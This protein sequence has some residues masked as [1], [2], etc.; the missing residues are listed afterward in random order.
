MGYDYILLFILAIICFTLI[1]GKKKYRENE[2]EPTKLVSNNDANGWLPAVAVVK[3]NPLIKEAMSGLQVIFPH[4]SDDEIKTKLSCKR[5]ILS[6]TP[7]LQVKNGL[8]EPGRAT[9][10]K[11]GRVYIYLVPIPLSDVAIEIRHHRGKIVSSRLV[12]YSQTIINTNPS[13]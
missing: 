8:D 2:Q 10:I 1:T 5:G 6:I 12:N 3:T 11:K 9:I 13:K 7:Q 4:L